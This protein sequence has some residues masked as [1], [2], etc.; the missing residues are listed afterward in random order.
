MPANRTKARL[1]IVNTE[2][3]KNRLR[4]RNQERETKLRKRHPIASQFFDENGIRPGKFR[5]HAA[6]LLSTGVLAGSLFLSGG[7]TTPP[8]HTLQDYKNESV[9]F[10]LS[11]MDL[12]NKLKS[13]LPESGNWKLTAEQESEISKDIGETY[14]VNAVPQLEGNKLNNDYGRMGAEQ[15]LPRYPG[16]TVHQHDELQTKGI[17][18]GRGAWGYFANSK[19]EMTDELYQ[20]EKWYVAVQTLYLPDWN[21]NLAYLRD[22]YKYRRVVVVNPENGKAVVAAVADAG[23]AAFTGKH[24]GGSPELMKYLHINHGMQNHPVILFFL[25]D[26]QKE[27]PLGPLEYNRSSNQEMLATNA[28]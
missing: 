13:I 14:G 6:K 7:T 15:H 27:V 10:A 8:A 25:D 17:T 9:N 2:P 26:P 20:T 24:F 4:I 16:D 23:P 1:E 21:T 3:L 12:A 18:P 19:E 22:W 28:I 5:D 11:Q